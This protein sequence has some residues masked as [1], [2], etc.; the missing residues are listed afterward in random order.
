MEKMFAFLDEYGNPNLDTKKRGV[1]KHFV[2]TSILV[3][4]LNL[5]RLTSAV[6]DVRRRHF[7]KGEMKSSSVGNNHRRRMKIL[8]DIGKLD[9]VFYAVA[10]N[11]ERVYEDSGLRFKKSFLKNINGKI[12]NKLFLTFSDIH[13]VADEHGSQEY[14]DSFRKY[15]EKNHKPDLFYKSNFELVPSVSNPLVQLADFLVGTIGKIY[16]GS[17]SQEVIEAY[18]S[19]IK[20]KCV[21]LREWPTKLGSYYTEDVT[22]DS[23]S[24][25][26]YN[27][28][29]NSAEVFIE[30]NESRMDEDIRLQVAVARYLVFH[31]RWVDQEAYLATKC[32]QTHLAD[33]GFGNVKQQRLRTHIIA[34]LRDDG[35][36]IASSPK[37]Y[38]IPNSFED[39]RSF[40]ETVNGRVKPLLQRLGKARS[41]LLLASK[42]E[43]DILKGPNYPH[44]VKFLAILGKP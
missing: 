12:F 2:I 14:K 40:V 18:R 21:G 42:G 35:V 11:K 36:I 13:I 10:V 15:I 25:L 34:K 17:A 23:Y 44:L 6:E 28:A 5:D 3:N 19:L 24:E 37:G 29:L 20:K 33:V 38:K 22:T 31:T 4:A 8:N 27:H 43:V 26:I 30:R 32:I 41:N 7:Q 1:S 39:M 9:F 16:D